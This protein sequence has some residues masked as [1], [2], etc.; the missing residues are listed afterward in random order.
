MSEK[1]N[2]K[3][4]QMMAAEIKSQHHFITNGRKQQWINTYLRYYGI[5]PEYACCFV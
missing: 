3:S 2:K 4:H 5:L 1:S